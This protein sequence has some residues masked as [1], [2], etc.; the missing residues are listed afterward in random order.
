MPTRGPIFAALGAGACALALAACGG[1]DPAPPAAVAAATPVAL[2]STPGA[3]SAVTA[4]T[5][6]AIAA[7]IDARADARRGR[8]HGRPPALVGRLTGAP[9][10][11]CGA[12]AAQTVA[13]AVGAVGRRLVAAE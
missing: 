9:V 7:R 1:G 6:R 3:C 12:N 10:H 11:A 5:L 2:S 4:R 8:A 13:D